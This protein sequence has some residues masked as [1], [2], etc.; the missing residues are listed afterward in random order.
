[1]GPE[2]LICLHPV[3]HGLQLLR[4]EL[5][6]AVPALLSRRDDPHPAQHAEVL[7]HCR[8]GNPEFSDKFADRVH[9]TA[10]QRV[11]DLAPPGLG[12][13]VEDVRGSR[14]SWHHMPL[15]SYMG[16]CQGPSPRAAGESWDPRRTLALTRELW[17]R[18]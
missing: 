17:A 9:S 14:R 16:I 11:D 8:L 6:Q 12:N 7:R 10:S 13:G 5:I 15:Y 4:V 18:V 3:V 1:M 2:T